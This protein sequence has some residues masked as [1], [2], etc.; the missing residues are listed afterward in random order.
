MPPPPWIL[1]NLCFSFLLDITA[2][3]REIKNNAYAKFGGQTRCLLGD[4]QVVNYV[5]QLL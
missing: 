1:H 4:V 3:P 5:G 2:V